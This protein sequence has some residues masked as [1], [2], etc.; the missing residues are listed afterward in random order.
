MGRAGAGYPP[1]LLV[2]G[3]LWG[4]AA[5]R[6]P[7]SWQARVGTWPAREEVAVLW[8]KREA[9]YSRKTRVSS[10]ASSKVFI[11]RLLCGRLRTQGS[12]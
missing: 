7:G 3:Q 9:A 10:K 2:P 12:I 1:L 5:D 8:A 6:I 11:T 4:I